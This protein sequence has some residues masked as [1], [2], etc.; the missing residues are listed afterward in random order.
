MTTHERQ[1]AHAWLAAARHTPLRIIRRFCLTR[2]L[3][4]CDDPHHA[5]RVDAAIERLPS[6]VAF[7]EA[8]DLALN[9]LA[10][11]MQVSALD[12]GP[13]AGIGFDHVMRVR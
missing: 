10:I 11:E 1:I 9:W 4:L 7:R 12:F 13:G 5:Q 6:E 2:A 3:R 8:A